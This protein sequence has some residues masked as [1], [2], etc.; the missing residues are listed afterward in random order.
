MLERNENWSCWSDSQSIAKDNIDGRIL[1]CDNKLKTWQY[2]TRPRYVWLKT[3]TLKVGSGIYGVGVIKATLDV[4][5]Y[6][7]KKKYVC[8]QSHVKKIFGQSALI[9]IFY[10]SFTISKTGNSRSRFQAAMDN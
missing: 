3:R 4:S 7:V 5:L 8:L 9:F 6:S 10:F 2:T 1:Y